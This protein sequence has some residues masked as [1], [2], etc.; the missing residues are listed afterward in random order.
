[1]VN[2]LE[3]QP[4]ATQLEL[5]TFAA[6]DQQVLVMQVQQLGGIAPAQCGR[7]CPASEYGQF[8]SHQKKNHAA[9]WF[10]KSMLRLTHDHAFGGFGLTRRHTVQVNACVQL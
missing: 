7:R 5:G 10:L 3:L 4:V 2:A 6:I 9:A 1:M 8:K